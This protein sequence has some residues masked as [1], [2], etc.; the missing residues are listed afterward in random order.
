M[1]NL[2]IID[3]QAVKLL[4]ASV[5][6]TTLEQCLEELIKNAL[7]ANATNIDIKADIE[8]TMIQVCDNGIG[9][10]SDYLLQIAQLMLLQ[11]VIL[12]KIYMKQKLL[13]IVAKF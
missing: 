11:S 9:I 12:S 6:I 3:Q 7:D 1:F 8:K 4:R 10:P 5:V 2:T 13:D